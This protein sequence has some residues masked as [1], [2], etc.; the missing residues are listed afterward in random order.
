MA[1]TPEPYKSPFGPRGRMEPTSFSAGTHYEFSEYPPPPHTPSLPPIPSPRSV[2]V[3]CSTALPMR[4]TTSSDITT[5]KP[6][7]LLDPYVAA[8]RIQSW[9]RGVTVRADKV[10]TFWRCSYAKVFFECAR[11]CRQYKAACII[12]R[13]TMQHLMG[14]AL[15]LT[16]IMTTL[17]KNHIH[18]IGYMHLR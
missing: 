15:H 8:R 14:D 6:R 9:W 12:Q 18:N 16:C 7:A 2:T 5:R 17:Y 1:T 10:V 4:D 11:V 13:F 3:S